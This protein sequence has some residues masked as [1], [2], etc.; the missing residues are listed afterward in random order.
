MRPAAVQERGPRGRPGPPAVTRLLL[1]GLTCVRPCLPPWSSFSPR[2]APLPQHSACS[3]IAGGRPGTSHD[4]PVESCLL[5]H[6]QPR[7]S[8]RVPLG[9]A[10]DWPVLLVRQ[11]L[12]V[13]EKGLG[14]SHLWPELHPLVGALRLPC[15]TG[16]LWGSGRKPRCQLGVGTRLALPGHTWEELTGSTSPSAPPHAWVAPRG[17]GTVR[18]RVGSPLPSC[19]L[20]RGAQ[21]WGRQEG[22]VLKGAEELGDLGRGHPTSARSGLG[23]PCPETG[24]PAPPLRCQERRWLPGVLASRERVHRG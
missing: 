10:Q 13:F 9:S 8:A 7:L 15:I 23:D 18:Q 5:P 16:L 21:S 20:P 19:T 11:L 4:T 22:T 12:L 24:S 2:G 1:P 6:P 3:S 17:A 14:C